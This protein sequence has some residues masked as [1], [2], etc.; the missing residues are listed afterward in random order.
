MPSQHAVALLF[1][2]TLRHSQSLSHDHLHCSTPGIHGHHLHQV[3]PHKVSTG[4]ISDLKTIPSSI[5][6]M[7][8]ISLVNH[9]LH[10]RDHLL[11]RAP[12]SSSTTQNPSTIALQPSS[13]IT[14]THLLH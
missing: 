5:F 8:S 12:Y 1:C 7:N 10:K 13:L 6:F 2:A 4:A 11:T 3:S 9:Y 14:D